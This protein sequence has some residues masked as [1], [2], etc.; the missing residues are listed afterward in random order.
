M[1][2]RA[3]HGDGYQAQ[4]PDQLARLQ[5]EP[6]RGLA[7]VAHEVPKAMV[8]VTPALARH[9]LAAALDLAQQRLD[10]GPHVLDANREPAGLP[11]AP[12]AQQ[13][14]RTGRIPPFAL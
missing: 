13:Q 9:P 14:P 11:P 5:K 2:Q 1:A 7:D 8:V 3:S 6:D 4:E 12:R 10:L